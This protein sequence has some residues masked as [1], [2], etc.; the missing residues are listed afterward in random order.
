MFPCGVNPLMIPPPPQTGGG[1]GIQPGPMCP[2]PVLVNGMDMGFCQDP[3]HPDG[4]PRFGMM[5][6]GL[7]R[8]PPRQNWLG[9]FVGGSPNDMPF[10]GR[11]TNSLDQID[12]LERGLEGMRIDHAAREREVPRGLRPPPGLFDMPVGHP[13]FE[14]DVP[15]A[16]Q[17]RRGR[18]GMPFDMP[19]FG[20]P[21][22][23]CGVLGYR[24]VKK[25]KTSGMSVAVNLVQ[26]EQRGRLFIE[27][28]VR[29]DGPRRARAIAE[30]NALHRIEH[31]RNLN[32]LVTHLW[33]PREAY[34]TF[35]LE[36]CD[37]GSLQDMID[38]H[39][40]SRRDI[41]EEFAW[42]VLLGIANGL[43]FLHFGTRDT[44][45]RGIADWD[46]ICHLD[47]KPAN[48]FL[49][50]TDQEGPYPRVV[51]GDFGCAITVSDIVYGMEHPRQQ[52]CG[53]PE[54][55][56]REG[57]PQVVGNYNTHYGPST[58]VVSIL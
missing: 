46:A 51:V 11:R 38:R 3:F 12:M 25:L 53:T 45:R 32:Y 58:D 47:L 2:Q 16:M 20:H 35:I 29:A 22:G 1:R 6:G 21:Q 57:L 44:S 23:G 54:W 18:F 49:S 19:G 34:C 28:H 50:T 37:A 36:Y 7:S 43:A 52:L 41:P 42:H 48:V 14:R 30:L 5:G 31:G 4:P 26:D 56:P 15:R 17:P 9:R 8:I 39:R 33:G 24:V 10:G 40:Q 27:K 13:P 55:Y